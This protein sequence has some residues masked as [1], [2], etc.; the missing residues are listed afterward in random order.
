MINSFDEFSS[1][2]MP[3]P[4]PF[5]IPKKLSFRNFFDFVLRGAPRSPRTPPSQPQSV[6]KVT[7]GSRFR[8]HLGPKVGPQTERPQDDPKALLKVALGFFLA[9]M[10]CCGHF[11][12]KKEMCPCFTR[13]FQTKGDRRSDGVGVHFGSI[14]YVNAL[15]RPFVD[16]ARSQRN[17][18]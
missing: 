5:G 6:P 8:E 14:W 17:L 2:L 11:L 18:R 10:S 15:R 9:K 4:C 3:K 12:D 1:K 16:H 13:Y 7:H